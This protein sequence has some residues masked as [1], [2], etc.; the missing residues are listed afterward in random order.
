MHDII[1]LEENVIRPEWVKECKMKVTISSVLRM[2]IGVKHVIIENCI[3]FDY[4][5]FDD[6]IAII[7]EL[8]DEE[9]L[10]IRIESANT[11][12]LIVR[13]LAPLIF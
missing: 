1:L 12:T 11:V 2:L 7:G 5:T 9:C 3:E 10:A 8:A 13:E 4:K 6:S